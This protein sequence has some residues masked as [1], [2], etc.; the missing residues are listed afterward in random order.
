M[1]VVLVEKKL[2][3]FGLANSHPLTF[4]RGEYTRCSMVIAAI[5]MNGL[6]NGLLPPLEPS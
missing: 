5:A 3:R 1:I 2:G 6:K 4:F